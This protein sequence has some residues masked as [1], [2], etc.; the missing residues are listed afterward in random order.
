M[1]KKLNFSNKYFSVEYIKSEYV[2]LSKYNTITN[3]SDIPIKID[4]VSSLTKD[5]SIFITNNLKL[6]KINEA[7]V[8]KYSFDPNKKNKELEKFC[9]KNWDNNKVRYPDDPSKWGYK[10]LRS[11][12]EKFD[13]YEFNCWYLPANTASSIHNLHAFTEVHTQIYGLGIMNKFKDEDKNTLYQRMY[14][15]I[16]FTHEYFY[17]SKVKY[18]WHQYEA[19]SECIWMAIMRY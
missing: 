7:L 8:I 16:G 13:N 19:V 2:L 17:D 12:I 1:I 9:I 4:S 15:P 5:K 6:A 11:P 18:P 3:L 14:M 10:I